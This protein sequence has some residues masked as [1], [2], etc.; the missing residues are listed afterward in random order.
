[1]TSRTWSLLLG[2]TLLAQIPAAAQSLAV[3]PRLGFFVPGA[4]LVDFG[5]PVTPNLRLE[6][7]PLAGSDVLL[8]LGNRW[9]GF[10]GSFQYAFSRLEHTSALVTRTPPERAS[11]VGL[12]TLTGGV[13]LTPSW[14]TH[15]RP[16]VLV[17]GGRA[18]GRAGARGRPRPPTP[19]PRRR[20]RGLRGRGGAR[21]RGR[22]QATRR[23][24]P[25]RS[26]ATGVTSDAA[27]LDGPASAASSA[28]QAPATAQAATTPASSLR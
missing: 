27:A 13:L 23:R 16:R 3:E 25:R 8:T 10:Y 22:G 12:F 2:G 26:R 18:G 15:V 21:R 1:M 9:L 14:W 5:S 24:P 17:G 7:G 28:C 19:A 4:P 11:P 20:R 6:P